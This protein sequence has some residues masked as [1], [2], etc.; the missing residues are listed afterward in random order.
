MT[1]VEVRLYS[2]RKGGSLE[3]AAGGVPAKCLGVKAKEEAVKGN[4][5]LTVPCKGR[6][7]CAHPPCHLQGRV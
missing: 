6:E 2:V 3:A 1:L 7:D 5:T 4:R